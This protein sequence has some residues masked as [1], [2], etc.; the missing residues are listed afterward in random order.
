MCTVQKTKE[1]L[2]RCYGKMATLETAASRSEEKPNAGD[3]E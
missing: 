3:E 1:V 2:R